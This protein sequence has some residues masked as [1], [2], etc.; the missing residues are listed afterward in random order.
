MAVLGDL[1]LEPAH[2]HLFEEARSQLRAAMP[3]AARSRV[4]QLGDLGGYRDA[5]G[6]LACFRTAA[7]YMNG[8]KVPYRLITGNHDLE[9]ERTCGRKALQRQPH[10]LQD[11]LAH[12]RGREAEYVQAE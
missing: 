5:P 4:V 8:F 7:D 2:M 6:S 11:A 9:G 3:D 1:H 12:A 10:P